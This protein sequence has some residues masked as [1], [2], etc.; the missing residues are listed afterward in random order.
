[1]PRARK[2]C[3]FPGCLTKV[4]GITY[5]DDHQPMNWRGDPRTSTAEHKAWRLAV[6]RRDHFRCQLKLPGCA[7]RATIG[8]HKVAVAFGGAELDVANG[9]AACSNC[10]AIKTQAESREGRRRAGQTGGPPPP[11]PSV[12]FPR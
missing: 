4:R 10:H 12:S 2:A 9:Q 8:D 1:M 5:C 7:G 11:P 6:L 3:G